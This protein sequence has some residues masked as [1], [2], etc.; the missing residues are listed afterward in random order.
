MQFMLAGAPWLVFVGAPSGSTYQANQNG[1]FVV[2]ANNSGDIAFLISSGCTPLTPFGAYTIPPLTSFKLAG[3]SFSTFGAMGANGDKGTSR[4]VWFPTLP[5]SAGVVQVVVG[6]WV[7]STSVGDVNYG[8]GLGGAFGQVTDNGTICYPGMDDVVGSWGPVTLAPGGMAVVPCTLSA[9][10]PAGAKVYLGTFSEPGS[11]SSGIPLYGGVENQGQF[12]QGPNTVGPDFFNSAL[13][14]AAEFSSSATDKTAALST[15]SSVAGNTPCLH[16]PLAI[17]A[18]QPASTPVVAVLSDSENTGFKGGPDA[19]NNLTPFARAFNG[20]VPVL[21]C[22]VS[23]KQAVVDAAAGFSGTGYLY[24]T[25]ARQAL[26]TLCGVTHVIIQLG[27]NDIVGASA[28]AATVEAALTTLYDRFSAM[29]MAVVGATLIPETQDSTDVGIPWLAANQT[30]LAGESARTAVNTWVRGVPSPLAFVLDPCPKV[31]STPGSG[32]WADNLTPDGVHPL[33]NAQVLIA[34]AVDTTKFVA[35]A[36]ATAIGYADTW[37]R[38]LK[39]VQAALDYLLDPADLGKEVHLASA[40]INFNITTDQAIALTGNV[41]ANYVV[42]KVVVRDPSISA[43]TAAQG[44]IYSAAGK[45][46]P[47]FGTTTTTPFADVSN[48][49]GAHV[50][51]GGASWRVPPGAAAIYFSLTT[52]QGVAATA[53]ADVYGVNLAA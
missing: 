21:N 1:I 48:V 19:L 33:W 20:L 40:T 34:S 24:A 36:P 9:A 38:G 5:L 2:P 47:L 53:T 27:A 37:S 35:A 45:S 32:I 6:N 42:T 15:I 13:G 29:G 49:G 44:G 12:S 39:N 41:P 14:E 46:G 30:V 52:A 7:N 16:G 50:F 28:S 17:L 18:L 4:K 22:A 26:M 43:L 8:S 10:I 31:E 51:G 11:G 3:S 25:S 23:G